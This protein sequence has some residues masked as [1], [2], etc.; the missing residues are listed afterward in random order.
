[1]ATFYTLTFTDQKNSICGEVVRQGCTGSNRAC[2]TQDIGWRISHLKSHHAETS[3]PLCAYYENGI[4]R[5]LTSPMITQALRSAASL[6]GASVG[7]LPEDVSCSC[8]WD[9]GAMAILCTQIDPLTI[10]LI[11][12]WRLDAIISY[13]HVQAAPIIN[14][15]ASRMLQLGNYHLLNNQSV[16]DILPAL[17]HEVSKSDLQAGNPNKP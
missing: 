15:I 16:L 8:L 4:W 3:T 17:E 5:Q 7:F 6:V 13:L 10:Q 12:R 14:N 2:A 9:G 1:M 11:G